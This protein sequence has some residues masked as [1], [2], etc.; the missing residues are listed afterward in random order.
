MT[1][2]TPVSFILIM[3]LVLCGCLLFFE[4]DASAAPTS[5]RIYIDADRT[6]VKASGVAIEQ[7]INTALSEVNHQVFGR[8]IDV[9]L[10]DH[11]GNT[12][13]SKRHLEAY[14]KDPQALVVYTGLHSP[15]VLANREF[16][17]KNQILT[18]DPW[19]AAGP[20]TRYPAQ[21]NWIFRLSIDDSK[22][23][24]VIIR[25][26]LKEGF[27]KPYL[28]LED[29]GWGK[30]NLKTMTAALKKH[31]MRPVG[32][33]WFNWN[34]G[35]NGAK[36]AIRK[37][38]NSG[39]DVVFLVANAPEAKTF[40]QA[41][42]KLPK[43]LQRPIRSHWGITGGDFS[44]VINAKMRKR[45]NLKFI[46]TRFSF[47]NP[48]QNPFSQGVFAQ[49]RKYYPRAIKTVK[50]I[51]APTGFI[52]AYDLTRVLLAAIRQARLTGNIIEDRKQVRRAL[53][54]L[55]EPVRGLIKTYHRPFRPFSK[56]DVDAHEALGIKEYTMGQY[57]PEGEIILDAD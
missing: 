15:P 45:I 49:A 13:R 46:Q 21:E 28:L 25:H 30:S 20:I 31:G 12:Q 33:E 9:V 36:F 4:N 48:L 10:K 35:E 53:E 41:M 52:H 3:G 50:D 38:A 26:A 51:K 27:K 55:Q 37:I 17:N 22:A 47:I 56:K 2:K 16:I 24:H 40:V 23:G 34:L 39:A 32:V 19:A 29:T 54:N 57:G 18:L 7:G 14:L 11:R 42:L 43:S 1:H 6:G 44:T 8:S 5:L